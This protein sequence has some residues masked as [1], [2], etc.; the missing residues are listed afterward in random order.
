MEKA[1]AASQAASEEIRSMTAQVTI[2]VSIKK[3]GTNKLFKNEK[4]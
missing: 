4:R 1:V 3:K 2:G